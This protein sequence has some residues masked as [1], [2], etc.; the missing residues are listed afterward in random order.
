M[1]ELLQE[2]MIAAWGLT[3]RGNKTANFAVL[4]DTAMPAELHEL[5]FITNTTDAAKLASTTARDQAAEAH[6]RA[7]Q[8]HFGIT[9]YIPTA[10]TTGGEADITGIVVDESG[11]VANATVVLDAD[12][13]LVTRPDGS[14]AFPGVASGTHEIVASAT[15]H[16]TTAV[17]VTVAAGVNQEIVIELERRAG[18]DPQGNDPDPTTPP[19]TTV[20]GCST[21]GSPGALALLLGLLVLALRRRRR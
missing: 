12:L 20:G 16:E 15:A 9:P 17:A 1:R 11:P 19:D 2:E 18:P 8:R 7:I 21:V 14:F 4:R 13:E 3:N 5:A 10:P 6:L